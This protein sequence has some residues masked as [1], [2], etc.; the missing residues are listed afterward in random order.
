MW[1][2]STRIKR[3][4]NTADRVASYRRCD[5]GGNKYRLMTEISFSSAVTAG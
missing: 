1:E 5:I 4:L 3:S 2:N